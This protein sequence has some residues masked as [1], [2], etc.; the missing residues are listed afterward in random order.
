MLRMPR[1]NK[2]HETAA[3]KT[4]LVL[5]LARGGMSAS[6]RWSAA[7]GTAVLG[8]PLPTAGTRRHSHPRV[9]VARGACPVPVDQCNAA[10][11]ILTPR[12]LWRLALV[13][14]ALLLTEAKEGTLLLCYQVLQSL[15]D[16]QTVTV[17]GGTL[18]CA[19]AFRWWDQET[20]AGEGPL[21]ETSQGTS[22][23]RQTRHLQKRRRE[24]RAGEMPCQGLFC[25]GR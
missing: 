14:A 21:E 15:G 4:A 3:W 2:Q 25:E 18:C 12:S 1:I 13:R 8:Q 16:T 20:E 17:T 19:A 10:C 23:S 6:N 24:K 9:T 22:V 7:A 5:A 11:Q